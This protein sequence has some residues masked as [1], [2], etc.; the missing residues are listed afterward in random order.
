MSL[1][2]VPL[3]KNPVN[4]ITVILMLVLAGIAGHLALKYFGASASGVSSRVATVKK[5]SSG[6]Y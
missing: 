4:W 6:G 2:N 5:N 1:L 3:L